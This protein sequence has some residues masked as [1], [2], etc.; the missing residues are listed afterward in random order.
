MSN[1]EHAPERT[2]DGPD[3]LL[4]SSHSN[5]V[6]I[7][8]SSIQSIDYIKDSLCITDGQPSTPP[9]SISQSGSKWTITLECGRK[10]SASVA[11]KFINICGGRYHSFS[12]TANSD[13]PG[14]LNFYFGVTI[15]LKLGGEIYYET[16]YLAQ[17][18]MGL[19]NNWWIGSRS[20]AQ[21][22]YAILVVQT[23]VTNEVEQVY[24]ISGGV[25]NFSLSPWFDKTFAFPDQPNWL[26]RLPDNQ[27]VGDINLPGTHDSAAINTWI[28]TPYATHYNTLGQQMRYGVRLLDIRLSVHETGSGTFNFITCHG[29]LGLNEYQSFIS[30]VDE[31]RSFLSAYPTEFIAMSLKVDDWNGLPNSK[32]PE[33]YQALKDLLSS[34]PVF[35]TANMPALGD[36][37][38]KIYLLNRMNDDLSLGVPIS[39]PDNTPGSWAPDKT[40]RAFRLYVQDQYKELGSGAEKTKF[41]LFTDAIGQ[42]VSGQMLLNFASATQGTPS[43]YGVYIMDLLLSYFGKKPAGERPARL[44]WSLFDYA[45]TDYTTDTYGDTNVLQLIIASNFAYADYEQTFRVDPGHDDL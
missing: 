11:D 15:G 36:V 43:I 21:K 25:S 4:V 28:P 18:H 23:P 24:N 29:D 26:Q 33:A 35:T 8:A 16:I 27:L 37:R 19:N 41:G 13:Q 45:S 17:G 9:P 1:L 7:D 3:R 31:C 32:K 30:A 20:L 39:W 40:K 6:E 44:G 10:G 5:I 22:S 34:Y 42:T 12:P 38:G 14:K 2:V